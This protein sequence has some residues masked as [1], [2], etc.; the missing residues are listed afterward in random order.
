MTG[1]EEQDGVWRV[2]GQDGTCVA[3]LFIDFNHQFN[4]KVLSR[5]MMTSIRQDQSMRDLGKLR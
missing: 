5:K 1:G 2:R 4:P 3:K